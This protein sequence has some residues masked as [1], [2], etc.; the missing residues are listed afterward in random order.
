MGVRAP[1]LLFMFE[2]LSIIC[3]REQIIMQLVM[4]FSVFSCY[5]LSEIKIFSSALSCDTL[6]LWSSLG[7]RDQVFHLYKFKRKIEDLYIL[8]LTILDRKYKFLS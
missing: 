8:I 5:V 6:N 3:R 4:R 2:H 7:M 1:T